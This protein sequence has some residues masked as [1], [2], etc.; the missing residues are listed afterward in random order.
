MEHE[1]SKGIWTPFGEYF[2]ILQYKIGV[3]GLKKSN[4]AMSDFLQIFLPIL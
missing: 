2:P 3:T 1:N 4:A